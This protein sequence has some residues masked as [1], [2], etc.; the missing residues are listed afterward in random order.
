LGWEDYLVG[1]LFFAGTVGAVG[2]AAWLVVRRR[3]PQLV[4]EARLLAFATVALSLLLAVHLLPLVLG[5]LSRWSVLVAAGAAL[6]VATRLPALGGRSPSPAPAPSRA[7][8]RAEWAL[9]GIGASAVLVA[10]VAYTA[11]YAVVPPQ[12]IDTLSFHLP[13]VVNWLQSGSVWRID[14]YIPDAANATYPHSGDLL[15]LTVMVPWDSE[16][17]VRLGNFPWWLLSGL[18]TFALARE[19][20]APAAA[21]VLAASLVAATP[22]VLRTAVFDVLSDPLLFAMFP[23]GALF[24]LR[25]RRTGDRS[26]LVLAGLALGLALGT[27]WYGVSAVGLVVLVWAG[28]WALATRSPL[29]ALRLGAPLAALV[30]VGGGFWFVRN[31]VEV[32]NPLHPLSVEA[33]GVTIFDAPPNRGFELVG[34]SI[35][36]Y[37]DDPGIVREILWPS[38]EAYIQ[39]GGALALVCAVAV[40]G[41]ALFDLRRG[42]RPR[43][44]VDERMGPLAL[45][46]VLIAAVYVVT[47]G[48]A[49]GLEGNPAQAGADARYVVPAL[50]LGA[51]LAAWACGRLGRYSLALEVL[52]ALALVDALSFAPPVSGSKLLVVLVALAAL[53][54]ALGVARR[55]WCR[56]DR[57]RPPLAAGASVV[58]A[59]GVVLAGHRVEERFLDGRYVGH[60]AT[61]DW[62]LANAPSGRKIGIAGRFSPDGLSP[63]EPIMGPRLGNEVD[64]VGRFDRGTLRELGSEA[65]FVRALRSGGYDLLMIGRGFPVPEPRAR[66]ESW[67]RAAGFSPVAQ[68]RRLALYSAPARAP[69]G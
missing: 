5:L 64:Y 52:I 18:A 3:F 22:A 57:L 68:S 20:R 13:I 31:W 47:P 7:S 41:A 21:S 54:A 49:L 66:E 56:Q 65:S 14:Q 63:V 59:L 8:G 36:D 46:A 19:L 23:T 45:C 42:S 43:L 39:L 4:R 61:V 38:I 33:F 24:L 50:T 62:V 28:A 16:A 55:L 15:M 60:D 69:A 12:N 1:L 35:A 51:A 2:A 58:V 40:L 67:A 9:A 10:A 44:L 29:G 17:F 11:D 34:F 48:S 32:G 25:H 37:L 26:D 6:A 53:A 27:K 30:A